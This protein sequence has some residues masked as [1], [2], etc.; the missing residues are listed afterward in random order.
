MAAGH[1]IEC[2]TIEPYLEKLSK[3]HLVTNHV[4]GCKRGNQ[5]LDVIF[6][7]RRT[8]DAILHSRSK[9]AIGQAQAEK[10]RTVGAV[11]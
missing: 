1:S 8:G 11:Q 3:E 10:L 5:T 4:Y 7:L 2:I 9:D 6:P